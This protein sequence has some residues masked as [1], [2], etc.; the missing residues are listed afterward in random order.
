MSRSYKTWNDFFESIKDKTYSKEL[1]E[2][3]NQEY[4]CHVCYPPRQKVFNAFMLTPLN[5]VKVVII[6]QDPYHEPNQAMGLAFSVPNGI[7]L[8]PSLINIYKEISNEYNVPVSRNGD[9]SYLATQGV[10]LLNA[11]LS[12]RKAEPL[13]HN[14]P[15]YK[16]FLKDVLMVL[17]GIDNPMVFLLWGGN[18]RKLKEYVHNPKHLV[19]ESVH[20]SPLSANRGGWFG[21]NHFRKTNE[22]LKANDIEEINW[23]KSSNN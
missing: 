5:N 17:D 6:G 19:L 8:P 22:F 4:S 12:V 1:Y 14:I 7:D 18:A 3:L 20:P 15:Q 10:L 13:S 23:I 2:F 16:E 9:L 21:N 11:S